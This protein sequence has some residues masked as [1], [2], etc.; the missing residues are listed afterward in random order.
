MRKTVLLLLLFSIALV[1]AGCAGFSASREN[2]YDDSLVVVGFSQVGSES[3]WRL[4]N[5]ASM[6]SALSEA[7]GYRLLFDNARQKQ[8]NQYL[9]IRNFIQ[10][11]VNYIV[12]APISET[13]WE[14][15]F[16][17]AKEAGIPVIV[18]D[19]QVNVEDESLYQSWVGS[20]FYQEGRMAV[21]WMEEQ[22]SEE[23]TPLRILHLQGT[24]GATAQLMRSR[25]L[26][27]A[28]SRHE[29]W[30]IEAALKGEF[31]EA[32]GY[33]VVR[34]FL[35]TGTAFD[36]LYSEND[37]M[38]FGAMRALDE[39]GISYG[40]EGKVKII[41][42]DAVRKALQFCLEG[43]INLCVEC[44]PLHGPRVDRLI[45]SCEAGETVPKSSY[46]E[47]TFFTCETIS[48]QVIDSREY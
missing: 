40:R 19:R 41:S 23:D 26:E 22:F 6:V 13:G 20:D 17:E 43:K 27:E 42:F 47:E 21:T 46:V 9:A 25:A 33:E 7:N 18:V 3:D 38:T 15:V 32:K 4:A 10:Q 39:A 35:K 48:Q 8:E 11:D 44:N 2:D 5:T 12:L 29:A 1:L 31:T 37:N 24:E 30:T 28:V 36:V 16:R 34:D 14:S 45:K